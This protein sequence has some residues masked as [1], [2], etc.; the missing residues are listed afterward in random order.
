MASTSA[1]MRRM[2]VL[3][4]VIIIVDFRA[5]AFLFFR[6]RPKPNH[7]STQEVQGHGKGGDEGVQSGC[8]IR[9]TDTQ[10]Q[11]RWDLPKLTGNRFTFEVKATN[12][13]H[14]ALSSQRHDMANMYE[15]VIGGWS[16]RKSVI[17]RRK[18]GTNRGTTWTSGINSKTEYRKFWITWSP[19]GTIAVG[20]GG[21]PQPFMKWTDPNPLPINYAGYTT[22]WGST[23][24]WRFCPNAGQQ[25]ITREAEYGFS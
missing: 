9:S 16:N 10:Y 20:R 3:L 15:I 2:F 22:G 8:Q 19:D 21:E 11:Y 17:R 5:E 4:L 13:V 1:T 14:V 6:P 24:L 25:H 12:D 23:G 7:G 18:Q